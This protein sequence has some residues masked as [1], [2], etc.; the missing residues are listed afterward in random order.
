MKR[1]QQIL[2]CL[3]ATAGLL[4][5][6][7]DTAAPEVASSA[8]TPVTA[9]GIQGVIV[10]AA[11]AEEFDLSEQYWTP[12]EEDVMKL[13]AA[14]PAYLEQ[15]GESELA[16]RLPEY[17]RQYVGFSFDGDRLLYA[18]FFCNPYDI[19]W[20]KEAVFILDGGNCYFQVQFSPEEEQFL[21]LQIN[22]ES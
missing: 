13:E 4:L 11:L 6:A 3:L 22:G 12:S 15:V 10:P 14:L 7:C 17:M 1:A 16:A 5:A 18:N 20:Q 2:I 8:Y 19:D 9:E 21:Y